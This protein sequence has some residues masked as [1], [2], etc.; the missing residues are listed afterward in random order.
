M[1]ENIENED[2]NS[3]LD[4]FELDESAKWKG[5]NPLHFICTK[6]P[7]KKLLSKLFKLY[8]VNDVDHDGKSA[9]HHYCCNEELEKEILKT[10]LDNKAEVNKMSFRNTTP[11]I[12]FAQK[13][14]IDLSCLQMLLEYKA[15]ANLNDHRGRNLF[16]HLSLNQNV[17]KEVIDYVISNKMIKKFDQL[18]FYGANALH[19]ICRIGNEHS[20]EIIKTFISLQFDL[21][22]KTFNEEPT[23]KKGPLHYLCENPNKKIESLKILIENK[24]KVNARDG[25]YKNALHCICENSYFD[26]EAFKFLVEHNSDL[27]VLSDSGESCFLSMC[28]NKSLKLEHL[29]LLVANGANVN[30][31]DNKGNNCLHFLAS[32]AAITQSIVDFFLNSKVNP[33]ILNRNLESPFHL[34]CESR[35]VSFGILQSLLRANSNPNISKEQFS[36]NILCNNESFNLNLIKLL[37]ENKCDP[38]KKNLKGKQS[39][40]YSCSNKNVDIEIIKYLVSMLSNPNSA[41]SKGKGFL[42]YL[43]LNESC[44]SE[45]VEFLL[46]FK[47]DP[48]TLS[49]KGR[50]SAFYAVH[51]ENNDMQIL[52]TLAE[53]KADF[54]LKDIS[55]RTCLH[56]LMSNEQISFEKL[57]FLIEKKLNL[58]TLDYNENSSFHIM[59]SQN[60][61]SLSILKLCLENKADLNLMNCDEKTPLHII[62][63]KDLIEEDLL[64]LILENK[65]DPNLIDYNDASPL[66]YIFQKKNVPLEI[67]EIMLQ[68][69][70]I[71]DVEDQ[72]KRR[73][74]DIVFETPKIST[75]TIDYL[76]GKNYLLE[77]PDHY[78][79]TPFIYLCQCIE[80]SD[81]SLEVLKHFLSRV[82]VDI[83]RK[84]SSKKT[85]LHYFLERNNPNIK[86]VE[87]LLSLGVEINA[88]DVDGVT[89]FFY[90]TN[91]GAKIELIEMLLSHNADVNAPNNYSIYPITICSTYS[92]EIT[93]LLV[94]HNANPFVYDQN[95]NNIL[96]AQVICISTPLEL[97][98]YSLELKINPNEVNN[99]NVTPFQYLSTN[100]FANKKILSLF[101]DYKA[102]PN[103]IRE[104]W[105]MSGKSA[106]LEIVENLNL[107]YELLKKILECK[108][109]PNLEDNNKMT[110]F[111][112][113]CEKYFNQETISLFLQHKADP[114][115]DYY[116]Q[117]PFIVS[118]RK[119]EITVDIL[120]LFLENGAKIDLNPVREDKYQRSWG[121][122]DYLMFNN[123]CTLEMLELLNQYGVDLKINNPLR[124]SNKY[125]SYPIYEYLLSIGCDPNCE[126]AHSKTPL[127]H[128]CE[129]SNNIE[130]F[131]L[132]ISKKADLNKVDMSYKTPLYH[133]INREQVDSEI[134]KLFLDSKSDPTKIDINGEN[135]LHRA[136]M[137]KNLS[138]DT[139]IIDY[140]IKKKCNI[141]LLSES[142]KTPVQYLFNTHMTNE[143]FQRFVRYGLD[144]NLKFR[145]N[146]NYLH[147]A[148]NSREPKLDIIKTILNSSISVNS[149]DNDLQN[150][151]HMSFRNREIPLDIIIYLLE[152]KINVEDRDYIENTPLHYLLNNQY[153]TNHMQI[154]KMIL[155]K[156]GDLNVTN[157]EK[158]TPFL[159]A[160]ANPYVDQDILEF[161][162]EKQANIHLTS[163]NSSEK[164]NFFNLICKKRNFSIEFLSSMIKSKINI[165]LQNKYGKTPLHYAC[166]T[167][168][169]YELVSLLLNNKA[170]P[171]IY[172]FYYEGS[173]YP[174]KGRSPFHVAL[175]SN[176]YKIIKLLILNGAKVNSQVSTPSSFYER[177]LI[178][179]FLE[180]DSAD[181]DHFGNHNYFTPLEFSYHIKS[182]KLFV[183]LL[184]SGADLVK[185]INNFFFFAIYFYFN[186]NFY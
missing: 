84:S 107:D 45:M 39:L 117:S 51:K 17:S 128:L 152:S 131:K 18:D 149:K 184:L 99:Y 62:C 56:H 29:E 172:D 8:D 28:S 186:F 61:V 68:Y 138:L 146:K 165:N 97:F 141:N 123:S 15:D 63:S 162:I 59:L 76:L 173:G 109:D 143:T 115:K 36:L 60:K 3:L 134:V 96:H 13:K 47:C 75:T 151:L 164:E 73:C 2:F 20:T 4:S 159:L 52:K 87:Y 170:D 101:L 5:M 93:K 43:L 144:L 183:L 126:D 121:A 83:F 67:V 142:A 90:A 57:E 148:V 53:Y 1:R 54:T 40:H 98:K 104:Q 92:L 78:G 30:I 147:L 88:K 125:L 105:F 111:L 182:P 89:P 140:V 100:R 161:L 94:K 7:E 181:D 177:N 168:C 74:F 82:D 156:K 33:N 127:H 119:K 155:E 55:G 19:Y 124:S 135:F 169:N 50:N 41:S 32:N 77:K 16:H 37:V 176:H 130:I 167:P 122:L 112:C 49:R 153:I 102:D 158:N 14:N 185:K 71:I 80:N 136:L 21:N 174:T 95:K 70:A 129:E 116:S 91:K 72:K 66:H 58:N 25:R 114:N 26:E 64:T 120:K 79:K 163:N 24:A 34:F 171:N 133:Y 180:F 65:A 108:G 137:H 118:C 27:N 175:H 44:S 6:K 48:N 69:G 179:R 160:C 11:F 23:P 38:K 139:E 22:L 103:A 113:V 157:K 150:C 106:F 86:I 35:Q 31:K 12:Y 42:D 154:L 145:G 46:R 110:P 81:S 132:F 178:G 85:I 166:K 10:L 9:L